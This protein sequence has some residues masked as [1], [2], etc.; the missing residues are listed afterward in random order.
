MNLQESLY[1]RLHDDAGVSALVGEQIY[2]LKAD[3]DAALP[4]VIY[5][6]IAGDTEHCMVSD[7]GVRGTRV[8]LA[9]WASSHATSLQ[10]AAAVQTCL[11]DFSGTLGGVGGVSCSRIF[12]ET[13][14]MDEFDESAEVEGL[15]VARQ[16]FT[17]WWE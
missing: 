3:Q 2:P 14:I 8:Q 10:V 4:L 15:W 11:K 5:Q 1:K 12:E 16:D 7:A 13:D 17:V 9:S 6:V